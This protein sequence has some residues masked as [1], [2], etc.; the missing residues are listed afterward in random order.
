[1]KRDRRFA[2]TSATKDA[3]SQG[4]Y[5]S[6]G[7][8]TRDLRRDRP[9]RVPRRSTTNVSER[10]RLQALLALMAPPLRTVEPI[11]QSAFGPRVGYETLPLQ[12][13][14][15]G[16]RAVADARARANEVALGLRQPVDDELVAVLEEP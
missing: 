4:I 10:D 15:R 1:M 14:V 11:V 8:R 6:D 5:G 2:P 7:T 3:D 9:S 12:T 16:Q 13:T